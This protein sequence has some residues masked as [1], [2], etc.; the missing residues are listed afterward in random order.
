MRHVVHTRTR[1]RKLYKP[2]KSLKLDVDE[3]V[4]AFTEG[5]YRS[6]GCAFVWPGGSVVEGPAELAGKGCLLLG[7]C[8]LSEGGDGI[9]TIDP[10]GELALEML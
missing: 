1:T 6:N 2:L 3:F 9:D 10:R 8:G 4:V 5:P 7:E